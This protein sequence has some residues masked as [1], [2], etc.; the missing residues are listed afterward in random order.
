MIADGGDGR[1]HLATLR[2]QAKLFGTVAADA[3]AWRCVDRVDQAHLLR[4][5]AVRPQARE[6]ASAAGAGPDLSA[7]LIIARRASAGESPAASPSPKTSSARAS[8]SS[9]GLAKKVE[10]RD[11]VVP[12]PVGL[13]QRGRDRAAVLPPDGE[14]RE[15]A[16]TTSAREPLSASQATN[17][18]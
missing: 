1:A 12:R 18:G 15:K 9:A 16:S 13:A 10:E 14:V 2:D 6:R 5:Q 17:A 3:T 11:R 8:K 4:L 7:V